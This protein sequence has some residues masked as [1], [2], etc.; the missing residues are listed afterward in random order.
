[1]NED[2]IYVIYGSSGKNMILELLERINIS[3]E[4]P[5]NA[6][7]GIKPNLVTPKKS[8]SGSTTDP[9][10]V[11]G[12]I[13]YLHKYNLREIIILE[14]AWYGASTLKAFEICGYK[15]LAKHYNVPL[16]D[17]KMKVLSGSV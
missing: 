8:D 12:L 14:G 4:I 15:D 9:E 2:E 17:L 3:E 10:I 7:I 13:E 1:M 16:Y 11:A 5:K 6:I